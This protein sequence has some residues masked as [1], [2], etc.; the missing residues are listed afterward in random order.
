MSQ[1]KAVALPPNIHLWDSCIVRVAALDP[2]TGNI[3]AGVTVSN[4]SLQ[5]DDVTGGSDQQL[6]SGTFQPILLR[7]GPG[8]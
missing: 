1:P 2:T 3:V 4:V 7:Q 6:A 8:A 5:V